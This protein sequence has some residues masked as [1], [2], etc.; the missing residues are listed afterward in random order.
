MN[1]GFEIKQTYVLPINM[2]FD[3]AIEMCNVNVGLE[4]LLIKQLF[5]PSMCC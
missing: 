3:D 4:E 5:H 2:L 1:V